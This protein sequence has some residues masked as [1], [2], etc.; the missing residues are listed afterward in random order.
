VFTSDSN[1]NYTGWSHPK[2]DRIMKKIRY[3]PKNAQGPFIK[4]AID[5]LTEEVPVIPLYRS[6]WSYLIK[7]R[8][9]DYQ[10]SPYAHSTYQF[11]SIGLEN[12]K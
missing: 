10:H 9:K 3:L 11:I 12:D 8:V 6:T 2:F 4:Q 1:A 7:K 5:L